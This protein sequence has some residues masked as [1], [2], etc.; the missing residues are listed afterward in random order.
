MRLLKIVGMNW[1]MVTIYKQKKIYY[2]RLRFYIAQSTALWGKYWSIL[3]I[4]RE[5]GLLD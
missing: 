5:D 3:Q 1:L 2:P 4:N